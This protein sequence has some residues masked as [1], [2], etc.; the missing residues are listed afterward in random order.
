MWFKNRSR[1]L[2]SSVTTKEVG[3]YC[4]IS[5]YVESLDLLESVTNSRCNNLFVR[6]I[7]IRK[8]FEGKGYTV[9]VTHVKG[10][11]VERRSQNIKVLTARTVAKLLEDANLFAESMPVESWDFY[12]ES[13]SSTEVLEKA[14]GMLSRDV[15]VACIAY[16]TII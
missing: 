14:H 9:F 4:V 3:T 16:K 7:S 8:G 12:S 15:F 5:F 6:G 1:V 2:E 13:R 10:Q 11:T